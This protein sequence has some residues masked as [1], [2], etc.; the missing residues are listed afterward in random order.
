MARKLASTSLKK[1][2]YSLFS[3]SDHEIKNGES[4][5]S[6][7]SND[8]LK[9]F[10]ERWVHDNFSYEN[11]EPKFSSVSKV[12]LINSIVHGTI[13][14]RKK[15]A[16]EFCWASRLSCGNFKLLGLFDIFYHWALS[17]SNKQIHEVLGEGILKFIGDERVSQY[18]ET[19][20]GKDYFM[21]MALRSISAPAY[22][23]IFQYKS[24]HIRVAG[25][26]IR[27]I[28]PINARRINFIRQDL[29]LIVE[30]NYFSLHSVENPWRYTDRAI[31]ELQRLG[32]DIK[33]DGVIGEN[34]FGSRSEIL[35]GIVLN[36]INLPGLYSGPFVYSFNNK[37]LCCGKI[38]SRGELNLVEIDLD[39]RSIICIDDKMVVPMAYSHRGDVVE[40]YDCWNNS[41]LT[42]KRDRVKCFHIMGF[43]RDVKFNDDINSLRST[44]GQG[45]LF[46]DSALR[47]VSDWSQSFSGNYDKCYTLGDFYLSKMYPVKI[48]LDG[49][50]GEI[51]TLVFSNE[52]DGF[53]ILQANSNLKYFI[54]SVHTFKKFM[55]EIGLVDEKRFNP[56]SLSAEKAHELVMR[57][58]NL[59]PRDSEEC[60]FWSWL[61]LKRT[62]LDGI[63][64]PFHPRI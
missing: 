12:L 9:E 40:A 53:Y 20:K 44:Q 34:Y 64:A 36:D 2:L 57:L 8:E 35:V 17:T 61:L 62:S 4:I 16:R 46:N 37:K 5:F 15:I 42:L 14:I 60:N 19:Q 58:S 13:S 50:S 43:L 22:L 7:L 10:S 48:F 38:N 32:V 45:F 55:Q 1:E 25:Y 54:K 21:G 24:E 23:N 6:S 11:Y 31:S 28:D 56:N 27:R 30:P 52:K 33:L 39:N 29:G 63:S 47:P 59:L 18:L 41:S 26:L 3:F 51:F 49:T